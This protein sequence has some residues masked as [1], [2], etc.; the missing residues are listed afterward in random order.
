MTAV[1]RTIGN[2]GPLPHP[3]PLTRPFEAAAEVELGELVYVTS[4]TKVNLAR[5]NAAGTSNSFGPVIAG[6]AA[7]PGV[8]T[9]PAG[10][11]VSVLIFGAMTGFSGMTVGNWY[12]LSSAVAGGLDTAIPANP[13]Y[14][15]AV[16]YA[17]AADILFVIPTGP[18]VQTPA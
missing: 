2:V 14:N 11:Q 17:I 10:S 13:N 12:Y 9:F 5:A 3:K 18:A 7:D 6:P 4:A 15:K 16:G 8:D 1:T